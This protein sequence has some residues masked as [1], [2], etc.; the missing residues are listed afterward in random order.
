MTR[1]SLSVVFILCLHLLNFNIA[2]AEVSFS[3]TLT[4]GRPISNAPG[5]FN[6]PSGLGVDSV[7][8]D[9]FVMDFN[10]KRIQRF[11][12]NGNYITQWPLSG[13]LGIAVDTSDHSVYVA[14]PSRNALFKYNPNGQIVWTIQGLGSGQSQFDRP[15]D[16]AVNPITRE[17][18]VLDSYNK[19][20]QKFTSDGNYVSEWSDN[21]F[22]NPHGISIDPT[23]NFIYIA[24]SQRHSIKKYTI[25]G[26]FILQ[27]GTLGNNPGQLRWPRSV[28]VNSL[29]NVYVTDSDNER[30]QEFGA[31]G[32]FIQI[33]QGPHDDLA[34]PFHPRAID[35][36]RTT[37]EIYVAAGYA[38]R[39]DRFNPDGSFIS[40]WGNH[41]KDGAVFNRPRGVAINP[42][43][44][45]IYVADT[46]NHLIKRFT[47]DGV[48]QE[49]YGKTVI[50]SRDDSAFQFPTRMAFDSNSNLWLLNRGLTYA[51][52]P[53]WASD[54]YVRQ[55]D[56]N[57]NFLSGFAH[58]DFKMRMS[59][60]ALDNINNRIYVVIPQLN[61]VTV[62][63]F[64]GTPLFEFGN[65][66]AGPGQFDNPGGIVLD[67]QNQAAYI[68]DSGNKR[69]QKFSLNGEFIMSFGSEGSD[70]GQFKIGNT[71]GI[72]LDRF[73]NLY[74]ADTGNKRIQVFDLEGQYTTEINLRSGFPTDIAI[75]NTTL[76]VANTGLQR[77]DVFEII[78]DELPN[79]APTIVGQPETGVLEGEFYSF[80]PDISDLDSGD[81]LILSIA[82]K[83]DWASFNIDTGELSGTPTTGD[84]GTTNSIVITVD[85]GSGVSNSM[86]SLAAFNLTVTSFNPPASDETVTPP[87]NTGS[88]SG[89]SLSTLPV[90]PLERADWWLLLS[91][92]VWMGA[93]IARRKY[94][95]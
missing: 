61:K 14:A 56:S 4:F 3:P 66:G 6:Y 1:Y 39:I 16:V 24:N 57:L 34:G 43:N 9:V 49:Q 41:E 22:L 50:I 86:T 85:D 87:T 89:C 25:D 62:F 2:S 38:H 47:S 80:I 55:F 95:E 63:D 73:S 33:I 75:N 13:G 31:D 83:P 5:E 30:V 36:N 10:F 70:P 67:L 74:V 65:R 48:F 77:I 12:L 52:D 37:N 44:E 69:I 92:I 42:A 19:R 45:D 90:S 35:I 29:G 71:S 27:W 15:R 53:T 7:S 21:S 20:V 76:V 94:T 51:D 32:N 93:R 11:D 8:G 46:D 78:P 68:I 72:A 40:S 28:S 26:T 64:I 59:G 91:F 81:Q 58:P 82:N 17:V 79:N 84:I 54:K 88:S 23:G 60:L 18:F